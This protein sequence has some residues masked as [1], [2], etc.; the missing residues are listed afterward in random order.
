[1]KTPS[2]ISSLFRWTGTS[3]TE[4]TF[5]FVQCKNSFWKLY[6]ISPGFYEN[7]LKRIKEKKYKN[8]PF[9]ELSFSELVVVVGTLISDDPDVPDV[10]VPDVEHPEV[11]D[12]PVA[13]SSNRESAS[14][15]LRGP[16]INVSVAPTKFG[17]VFRLRTD[18]WG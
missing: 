2:L 9:S 7:N 11:P 13:A 1:M 16:S 12:L 5:V 10:D 6:K 18:F 15:L 8:I 14:I 3:Q 17:R 4:N